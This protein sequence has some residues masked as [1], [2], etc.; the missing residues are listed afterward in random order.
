MGLRRN[1][2]QPFGGG[3]ATMQDLSQP[4]EEMLRSRYGLQ[5]SLASSGALLRKLHAGNAGAKVAQ[6]VVN[7]QGKLLG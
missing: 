1:N 3:M 6:A 7:G 5:T 2:G 4:P